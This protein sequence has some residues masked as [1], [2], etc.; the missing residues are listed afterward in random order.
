MVSKCELTISTS[1]VPDWTYVEA[2][3]E[4][5]QNAI[6]NEIENPK[7][8]MGFEFSCNDGIGIMRISNKTSV[9]EIKSLLLGCSTKRDDTNTIGKHGEGYK[10]AFMVLLREGKKIKVYNYGAREIWEV[11]LVKSKKFKGELIPT[12]LIEKEAIWKRVPNN[13][14]IIE[15]TGVTEDEYSEIVHRNLNLRHTESI[16]IPGVGRIL[17]DTKNESGNIYV[18]GL[19][20]CNHKEFKYG[21]DFEP[22]MIELDRDR[23]LVRDFDLKWNTS[24]LLNHIYVQHKEFRD[25]ILELVES[26]SIDSFFL[27][28]TNKFIMPSEDRHT[29]A[30]ELNNR[31]KANYGESSLPVS[32]NTNIAKA[33]EHGYKPVLISSTAYKILQA[34]FDIESKLKTKTIKERFAELLDKI[35]GKLDNEEVEEFQALINEL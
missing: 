23:K 27:V 1:Y 6:D 5:F 25:K 31:F 24:T 3:R 12:V 18:S 22:N 13:N 14:L 11:K 35:E 32:D 30:T 9:L 16:K 33:V 2:F 15:V 26:D 28:E 7:N 29:M 17:T 8:K 10:I 19:Y 34:E 4:L 20:I 21:Y